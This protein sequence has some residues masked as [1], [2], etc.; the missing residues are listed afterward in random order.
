M[1][2]SDGRANLGD[3]VSEARLLRAEGV[4]VDTVALPV[5]VGAEAYVDRLD[6]PLTLTQGQ[7]AN[8]QALIVAN[9]ATHATVRWY[10]DRTLLNTVQLD[11]PVGETII[12]QTVTP[13]SL[14][15]RRNS[16]TRSSAPRRSRISSTTAR[17][18]RSRSRVWRGGGLSSGRS[19]TSARR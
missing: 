11:L 5:P 3:A 1:L 19:S 17:Y 18:S 16:R 14:I 4:R 8:A 6:A 10:L 7:Q 13:G 12:K 15:A 2:V 9:T